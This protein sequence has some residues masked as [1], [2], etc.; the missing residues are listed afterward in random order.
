MTSDKLNAE[1]SARICR[2]MNDDHSAA[3]LAYA[4]HYGELKTAI[5]AQ[6][7][8]IS[9]SE[10]TLS[11]DGQSLSIPFDHILIDSEDAHQT[12]ATMFRAMPKPL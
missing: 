6:M 5:K 12:L 11:V 4:K 7:V 3:V 1:V 9:P 8:A 2:H 10:M